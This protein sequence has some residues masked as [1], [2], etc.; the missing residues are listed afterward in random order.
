MRWNE[1]CRYLGEA[2]DGSKYDLDDVLQDTSGQNHKRCFV[3][4]IM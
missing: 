1:D 2:D 3:R 4:M